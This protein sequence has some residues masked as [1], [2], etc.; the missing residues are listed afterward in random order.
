M[1][2]WF[3][4][5]LFLLFLSS[6]ALA[7]GTAYVAELSGA[8]NPVSAGYIVRALSD[9][10]D[11][12]ELFVLLLDTPGGLAS[13]MD[14]I[15]RAFLNS[16]I[17][18]VTYV[19]PRGARAASAGA[20]IMMASHIA[21]MSPGT[22][23]GAAHPVAIQ[24]IPTGGEKVTMPEEMVHKVTNDAVANIRSIA[25][26]R[27]RNAELAEKF[28]RESIS[29]TETEALDSN[30]IDIISSNLSELLDSLDGKEIDMNGERVVLSSS[31]LNIYKR[32]M[33]PKEKFLFRVLDPNIAYLLMMLG[34][35]GIFFELSHPGAMFPGV[36][37]GISLLLALYAFQILPINYAGIFLIL[38][39]IVLFIIDIKVP[40]YGLL[41]LGGIVSLLVGSFLLTSGNEEFLR[42][43]W[44][45]ILPT[46]IFVAAFFI[47]VI[48]A[49]LLA[50]K[51]RIKTGIKGIIGETGYAVDDFTDGSGKVFVHGEYWHAS[52]LDPI[53]KGDEVIVTD[54]SGMTL[55]VKPK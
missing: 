15:T 28:V 4:V 23:I 2:R 41:S 48:A 39:G 30:I 51:R 34:I 44:R 1:R 25:N 29:L 33:N 9:A 12:A 20:F 14:D 55:T 36:V 21:A 13:S 42:I 6:S 31:D 24:P 10:Q 38:F 53:K 11:K 54:V 45:T 46:V 52:S 27:G 49:A 18:V 47:F 32:A 37:G 35:L 19:Y 17:P 7:A 22:H 43:S 3:L 40:S 26:L 5:I 16:H 50:Q 8:I